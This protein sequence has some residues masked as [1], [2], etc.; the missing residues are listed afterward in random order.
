[1][2][3]DTQP[4]FNLLTHSNVD[5]HLDS[6]QFL[7]VVDN[8][9]MNIVT[10]IFF[11]NYICFLININMCFLIPMSR[12]CI[13]SILLDTENGFMRWICQFTLPS[14][15][16]ESSSCS[17]STPQHLVLL[18]HLMTF[19]FSCTLIVRKEMILK[20]VSFYTVR[21]EVK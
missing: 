6:F 13:Y 2:N 8:A 3:R 17:P 9:V 1:M 18:K 11:K 12:I 7:A 16:C 5:K 10:Y 19:L 21:K 15:V 4:L 14:A 20:T